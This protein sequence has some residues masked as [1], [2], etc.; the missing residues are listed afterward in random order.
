M[1]V[2]RNSMSRF[3]YYTYK[4]VNGFGNGFNGFRQFGAA[5]SPTV[6]IVVG[7][8]SAAQSPTYTPG[9]SVIKTSTD[10]IV[11]SDVATT[12]FGNNA[13]TQIA[14]GNDVFVAMGGGNTIATSPGT[15][16]TT[17]TQR[18][19]PASGTAAWGYLT[20]QNGIFVAVNT[21][22]IAYTS[23]DGITWT[24]GAAIATTGL[25]TM[26]PS[27]SNKGGLFYI[28]SNPLSARWLHCYGQN[29]A[30]ASQTHFAL[31][32]DITSSGTI[33]STYATDRLWKSGTTVDFR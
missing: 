6:A 12:S 14:Y 3:P 5:A 4:E 23:T 31:Y 28:A 16:G 1:S 11:W 15:S 18:T 27:T 2:A 30:V 17:W 20:F 10:G 13:V 8:N 29:F 21:A 9:G 19:S 25:T 32:Q 33:S 22:S 26:A 7:T 24:A